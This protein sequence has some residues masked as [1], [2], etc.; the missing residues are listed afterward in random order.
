[1]TRHYRQQLAVL[2]RRQR[3]LAYRTIPRRRLRLPQTP[4]IPA[5]L[6]QLPPPS[7]NPYL[8][9]ERHCPSVPY[10]GPR[11]S[12][13][14]STTWLFVHS[15]H[16]V[17]ALRPSSAALSQRTHHGMLKLNTRHADVPRRAA[18]SPGANADTPTAQ[19][20][21]P[22]LRQLRQCPRRTGHSGPLRGDDWR[23]QPHRLNSRDPATARSPARRRQSDC[24]RDAAQQRNSHDSQVATPISPLPCPEH[25]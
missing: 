19:R 25:E 1:M 11:T 9:P 5:R 22:S 17:D 24:G 6:Q 23:I 16:L 12:R 20:P 14:P 18:H 21:S 8:R 13:Q 3:S 4:S 7:T 2:H 10:P 15:L